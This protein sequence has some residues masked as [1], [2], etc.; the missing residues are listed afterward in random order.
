MEYKGKDKHKIALF[1]GKQDKLTAGDNIT[2]TPQ[3]D[4]TVRIDAEGGGGAG[5]VT[6]VLVDGQSVVDQDGV[7]EITL[8]SEFTGATSQQAGTHGLVPAPAV[9]DK[10]KF[11]KGDGTWGEAGGGNVDDVQ[12][13]GQSIVD[14]NKVARFKN[15]VELTQAE[16]DALPPSKLTDGILYCIKDTGIVEGNK[17]APVIYSLE[18]REIGVWSNGKPLYQKT[19]DCGTLLDN[20]TKNI[21]I[22]ST[23]EYIVSYRG[24]IH[25]TTDNTS[26]KPI[27]FSAGGSNDIRVDKIGTNLR[28]ITFTNYWSVYNGFLTIQY[29][30]TTDVP[31]SGKWGTDGVPRMSADY[32]TALYSQSTSSWSAELTYTAPKYCVVDLRMKSDGYNWL[33]IYVNGN[34]VFSQVDNVERQHTLFLKPGDILSKRVMSDSHTITV[35]YRIFEMV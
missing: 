3:Q 11:L 2:L 30:K 27:P 15:Y 20:S 25:S 22:D 4:G 12:M 24:F 9:A 28:I 1:E 16:Y 17:F 34:V 29:T 23:I 13:N 32:S 14:G 33:E 35:A 5:T 7:A 31:G 18:E 21:P 10:D 26:Q 19:I 8:P 6:D